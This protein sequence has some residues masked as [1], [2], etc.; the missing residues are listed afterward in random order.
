MERNLGAT[1][2]TDQPT[3]IYYGRR[4]AMIAECSAHVGTEG[5]WLV[6]PYGEAR[7]TT[8]GVDSEAD[9]RAIAKEYAQQTGAK[10]VRV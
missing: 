4:E 9:A 7:F 3:H 8:E 6:M 2:M 10:L 1:R 5:K